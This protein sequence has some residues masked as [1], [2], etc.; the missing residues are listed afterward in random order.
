M[1]VLNI[2][3]AGNS[4]WS[5]LNFRRNLIEK[6]ISEGHKVWIIAPEDAA[7]GDLKALGCFF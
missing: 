7:V 6:I 3:L 1:K 2:A 5:I 4:A